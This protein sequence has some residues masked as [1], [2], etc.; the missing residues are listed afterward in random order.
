M[1]RELWWE[2]RPTPRQPGAETDGAQDGQREPFDITEGQDPPQPRV[3]RRQPR[4]LP[5]L[6]HTNRRAGGAESTSRY[7][8]CVF[9]STFH[10]NVTATRTKCSVSGS[11]TPSAGG[12]RAGGSDSGQGQ[13][14]ALCLPPT[15]TSSLLPRPLGPTSQVA[16]GATF[17]QEAHPCGYF[18]GRVSTKK[19][20][21]ALDPTQPGR[22]MTE[23]PERVRVDV[24]F[25]RWGFRAQVCPTP[26]PPNPT[27]SRILFQA[28]LRAAKGK[29][30]AR[31]PHHPQSRDSGGPS[32]LYLK[33]SQTTNCLETRLP[34]NN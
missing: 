14:E 32:L 6:T 23:W 8:Y 11:G 12:D 19:R 1:A 28:A 25:K 21:E 7:D 22:K 17:R 16:L 34:V 30:W 9:F 10:P 26:R 24:V 13:G 18:A 5:R 31:V 3:P 4:P 33:G 27:L 2:G 29:G 20:E 15:H